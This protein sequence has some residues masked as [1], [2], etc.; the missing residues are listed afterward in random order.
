MPAHA[1]TRANVLTA[2]PYLVTEMEGAKA[3]ARLCSDLDVPLTVLDDP[4]GPLLYRDFLRFYEQ[5]GRLTAMRSFGLMVGTQL[6]FARD[7]STFGKYVTS[8][9]HLASALERACKTIRHHESFSH[10]QVTALG[11]TIKLA[12]GAAELVGGNWRQVSDAILCALVDLV[13]SYAG[14]GW[15]PK[16][17]EVPY[18]KGPWIQDLEDC[19]EAPVKPDCPAIAVIFDEELTGAKPYGSNRTSAPITRADVA[20]QGQKLPKDITA[21]S[22]AIVRQRLL[23]GRTDLDGVAAKFGLGLRTYQRRLQ[24]EGLSYNRLLANCLQE[25]ARELLHED[26]VTVWQIARALGYATEIEFIRAFKKWTGTTPG[27]YRRIH[28]CKRTS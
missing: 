23:I 8:A 15:R 6:R 19:F 12:Y 18:A 16:W 28:L 17:V 27:A 22:Y 20:R 25:R 21:A 13:R 14:P 24:E 11:D 5:A 1:V 10:V 2:L 4:D 26:G 7:L 9:P 3:F